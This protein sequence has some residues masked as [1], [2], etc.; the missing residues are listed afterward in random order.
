MGLVVTIFSWIVEKFTKVEE[1]WTKRTIHGNPVYGNY[2]TAGFGLTTAWP[3]MIMERPGPEELVEAAPKIKRATITDLEVPWSAVE[4]KW[5]RE[6]KGPTSYDWHELREFAKKLEADDPP[7]TDDI[8]NQ[9]VKDPC[10]KNTEVEKN[11]RCDE[12]IGTYEEDQGQENNQQTLPE[13]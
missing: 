4:A 6:K 11:N 12:K 10:E 5:K 1:K 9:P 3:G 13:L 8:M 2:E 7:G